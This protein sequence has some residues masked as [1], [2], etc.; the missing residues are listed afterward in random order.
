QKAVLALEIE[1][2]LA[3]EA[4][5]KEAQRKTTFQKI[6]KS[7]LPPVHATQ[8]AAAI[9]GTNRQYVSDA[10]K[11]AQQ[12]PEIIQQVRNGSVT[13]PDAKR[14][15]NLSSDRREKVLQKVVNGTD[16]KTAIMQ[17]TPKGGKTS[18]DPGLAKALQGD[19][20]PI[21]FREALV[22]LFNLIAV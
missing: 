16:F 6:E 22:K 21:K 14:Y 20:A 9:V 8:Q 3:E 18:L 10:K 15:S 1:K 19:L 2:L 7:S 5:E 4:K 12:A 17:A 11:I 13:I